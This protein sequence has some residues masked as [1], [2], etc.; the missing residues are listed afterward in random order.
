MA[1][2]K[3]CQCSCIDGFT[4]IVYFCIIL[5]SGVIVAVLQLDQKINHGTCVI[6]NFNSSIA[7]KVPEN[8]N[9]VVCQWFEYACF[10]LILIAVF[11]MITNWAF[12][13]STI[14]GWWA[15]Q[16]VVGSIATA[17]S[18]MMGVVLTTMLLILCGQLYTATNEASCIAAVANFDKVANLNN[19][20]S[21]IIEVAFDHRVVAVSAA[22][23]V[24]L[25]WLL[26]LLLALL[27]T[28]TKCYQKQVA[29]L[30]QMADNIREALRCE[31]QQH[32]R[33]RLLRQIGYAPDAPPTYT[34]IIA[35]Q[36]PPRYGEDEPLI[37]F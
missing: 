17:L 9:T 21:K 11:F 12:G 24:F 1:N 4:A 23:L 29:N 31:E 33:Q 15:V 18:L 35:S 3:P 14:V 28:C 19:E 5:G 20:S 36:P 2:C 32:R 22:W 10:V 8:F 26:I 25:G 34:A 30:E 13:F 6:L 7:L 16:L 27:Q 37:Q